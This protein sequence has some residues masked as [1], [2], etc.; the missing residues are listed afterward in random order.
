MHGSEAYAY[1][2]MQYKWYSSISYEGA[3]DHLKPVDIAQWT[4][5]LVHHAQSPPRF[6]PQSFEDAAVRLLSQILTVADIDIHNAVFV[7]IFLAN[8][9]R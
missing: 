7:Y 2:R 1:V 5:A 6:Y 9:M 4:H 3:T 8:N